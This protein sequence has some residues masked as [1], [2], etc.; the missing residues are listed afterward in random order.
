MSALI[1]RGYLSDG[2]QPQL[3]G[4]GLAEFVRSQCAAAACPEVPEP[5]KLEPPITSG[6]RIPVPLNTLAPVRRVALVLGVN[7]YRHQHMGDY[8]LPPLRYAERDAEEI[9]ALLTLLGFEVQCLLGPQATVM[10]VGDALTAVQQASA[11]KPDPG[12]CFVFPFRATGKWTHMMM[13]RLT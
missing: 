7:Q 8:Y 13:R 10:A 2:D 1:A 11:A 6:P 3:F 9:A 12:S 5:A 4:E